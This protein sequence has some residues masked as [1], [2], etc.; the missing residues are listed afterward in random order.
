MT[1]LLIIDDHARKQAAEV[2]AYA[3]THPYHAGPGVPP[4][5]DNPHHVV[6]LNTYRCA[7]SITH[8]DGHQWRHLS[9]GVP[10]DTLLPN[11]LSVFC[12]A[13]LFGFT[14][15]DGKTFDRAP[16]SWAVGIEVVYNAI[17]VAQ[18]LVPA[19]VH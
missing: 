4:P 1:R 18:P 12:I 16:D 5:G 3:E 19:T 2:V 17:V 15:W 13:E 6:H 7:F 8:S 11:P 9:I 14:G 10:S